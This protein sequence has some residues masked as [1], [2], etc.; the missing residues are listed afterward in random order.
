ML[1]TK[2]FVAPYLTVLIPLALLPTIPP[3]VAEAPGSGGK[4]RPNRERY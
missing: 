1:R 3:I 4:K 2:S